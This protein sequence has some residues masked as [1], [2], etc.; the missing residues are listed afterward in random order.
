MDPL[1]ASHGDSNRLW[2]PQAQTPILVPCPLPGRRTAWIAS[3]RHSM[4]SKP[5]SRRMSPKVHPPHL[6]LEISDALNATPVSRRTIQGCWKCAYNAT[7]LLQDHCIQQISGR[8]PIF[9]KGVRLEGWRSVGMHEQFGVEP[10]ARFPNTS[11]S[12]AVHIY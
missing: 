10:D 6:H 1:N 3:P 7:E 8:N 5:T 11:P 9:A 2:P 4:P 12:L